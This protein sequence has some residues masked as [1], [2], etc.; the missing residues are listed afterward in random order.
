[1]NVDRKKVSKSVQAILAVG[2]LGAAAT[3]SASCRTD[4]LGCAANASGMLLACAAATDAL[5]TIPV[6]D[7]ACAVEAASASAACI[8]MAENCG[9]DTTSNNPATT[10]AG[11][12]GS[13]TLTKQTYTCGTASGGGSG[14][15]NRVTGIYAKKML[16][17]G[18][19]YY[20]VSSIKMQ[21]AKGSAIFVGNNGVDGTTWSGG[22]C[23]NGK[24]VQGIAFR[25]GS[26]VD[27]IGRICD[28][29][30]YSS[31]DSDNSTGALVGDP[32]GGS[33]VDK[34]CPEGK[35]VFGLNVWYDNTLPLASRFVRGVEP[36]CRGH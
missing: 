9:R 6:F 31:T 24:M 8:A 10:S 35:Y 18:S 22:T 4:A 21:C 28:T 1:M 3:A 5:G 19:D 34:L 13:G 33:R 15:E 29:V 36:L 32:D 12:V 7:Y 14:Y 2:L 26:W 27:A 23:A 30:S 25:A 11:L 20:L 16:R 17:S